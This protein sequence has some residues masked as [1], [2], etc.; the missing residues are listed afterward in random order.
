MKTRF[1]CAIA[2]LLLFACN[3]KEERVY[4]STSVFGKWKEYQ[5]YSDPGDGSGTFQN[6]NGVVLAINNDSTYT[7]TPE[8]YAWGT[9]GKIEFV[10][11]S[12]FSIKRNP[13]AT[14][15]WFAVARNYNNTLEIGYSCIEGCGS[16][17][18]RA[19]DN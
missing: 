16:R 7:C 3:K 15:T 10:N 12:L 18:K 19:D 13:I 11:D 8:H 6:V 17:F 1:I 4:D 5:A 2:V 14:G 9:N